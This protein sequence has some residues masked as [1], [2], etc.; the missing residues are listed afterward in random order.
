MEA[1]H[2]MRAVARQF[3]AIVPRRAAIVAIMQ[4][5]ALEMLAGKSLVQLLP[6]FLRKRG[7]R[8]ALSQHRVDVVA[9]VGDLFAPR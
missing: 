8:I 3:A 9:S 4:F 1:A 5:H 2:P 6:V 7:I